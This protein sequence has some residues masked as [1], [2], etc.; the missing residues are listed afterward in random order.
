MRRRVVRPLGLLVGL[1]ALASA[2]AHVPQFPTGGGPFD[3]DRPT[4]S[5]AYYLHL[6]TGETH[7]FV[8]PPL[9]RAIPVQVLV[10]DDERG[11]AI[12]HRARVDCGD[13]WRD[14]REVDAAFYEP[15]SR[16]HHRY[17]VVDAIGPSAT[18]CRV[19]VTQVD[20]PSAPYTFSIGDEERFSVGDILGLATLGARLE[21]WREGP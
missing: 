13:G 11:R 1:L 20:G 21:A 4:I 18:P 10:L 16:I 7:A 19:E 14:L 6:A 17:R 3:V 2:L 5:K 12:A 8:V 9:A 15:F